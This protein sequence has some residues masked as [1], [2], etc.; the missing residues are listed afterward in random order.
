[1]SI[2]R[3]KH[4]Q[5]FTVLPNKTLRDPRLSISALGV[6]CRLLSRPCGWQVR[7]EPLAAECRIGRDQL[8]KILREL[9]ETG[10]LTRTRRAENGRWTWDSEVRDTSSIA[11]KSVDG[12]PGDKES[13]EDES[14]ENIKTTGAPRQV[15]PATPGGCPP[16]TQ[17]LSLPSCAKTKRRA[18]PK[19]I[20]ATAPG[21]D[22]PRF[23]ELWSI[24]PRR[25]DH[26]RHSGRLRAAAWEQ[27]QRLR[28]D[29]V[30][31]GEVLRAARAWRASEAMRA[32]TKGANPWAILGLLSFLG[33][34]G[35]GDYEGDGAW[36]DFL[37]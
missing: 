7:P 28:D 22:D 16:I 2:I 29:G 25:L 6:L 3:I 18:E 24:F 13:T 20:P 30:D 14:T 5:F 35:S 23:I 8:R 9:E 32:S 27:W 33:A 15:V 26:N 37:P 17:P 12:F 21:A 36:R 4:T 34:P 31:L 1:M 10:Y 19:P 11:W